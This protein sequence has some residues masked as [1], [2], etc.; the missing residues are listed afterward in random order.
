[1]CVLSARVAAPGR[2]VLCLCVP[3]SEL[4]RGRYVASAGVAVLSPA[5][6]FPIV[7]MDNHFNEN[8]RRLYLFDLSTDAGI[9]DFLQLIRS[10]AVNSFDP[11]SL[12]L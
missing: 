6:T 10:T 12:L 2:P 8:L 5:I 7:P 9:A 1:M 11:A 4:V 3:M